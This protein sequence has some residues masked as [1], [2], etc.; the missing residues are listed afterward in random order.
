MRA[1]RRLPGHRYR[2]RHLNV[3]HIPPT[4]PLRRKRRTD[5]LPC[6]KTNTKN[7]FGPEGLRRTL[8]V[9][10]EK[11]HGGVPAVCIGGIN[12]SNIPQVLFRGSPPEKPLDGVAVVSAIMAADDPEAESRR[13]L[14]LVREAASRNSQ[15]RTGPSSAATKEELLKLVPGA[16]KAVHDQKPLSHNMTNLVWCSGWR[17]AV[18]DRALI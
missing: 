6:S 12:A 13:L 5:P 14:G 7:V 17:G 18:Q 10:A 16:I 11:G 15:P 3:R 1:G 8:A 2:L 9:L 4:F